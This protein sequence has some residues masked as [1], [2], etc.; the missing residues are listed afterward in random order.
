MSFVAVRE[1]VLSRKAY[2]DYPGGTSLQHWH[3]ALLRSAMGSEGFGNTICLPLPD[4]ERF[5][6][7]NV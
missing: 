3:R 2:A 7:P 4:V 1:D 5:N 6:N